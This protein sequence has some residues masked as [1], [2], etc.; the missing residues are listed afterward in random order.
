MNAITPTPPSFLVGYWRPWNEAADAFASY[1]DYTRDVSLAKYSAGI[2]GTY[3]AQASQERVQAIERAS[4]GLGQGFAQ[5]F[6]QL[7]GQLSSVQTGLEFLN[8][9]MDMLVEQQRLSNV[10]LQNI[11]ELLRV[12]NSEKERQHS[13]ELGI[14]FF[15]N[16]SK[17]PDLYDD[18]LEMLLKA[19]SLMKQD[20]FVL[21]RIGCIYLYVTKHLDPAKAIDYFSRAGKYASV[22]SDPK[23]L[24][25]A[26]VLTASRNA[27]GSTLKQSPDGIR[28]LAADAYEKAAF[29]AYILDK[30]EQAVGLQQKALAMNPSPQ[31]SFTLAKYQVRHGAVNDAVVSL[32]DALNRGPLLLGAVFREI[33][34]LNEPSVLAL[35]DTHGIA[36]DV[37]AIRG[38]RSRVIDCIIQNTKTQWGNALNRFPG[39]R[40]MLN[41]PQRRG[42]RQPHIKKL[43]NAIGK[44]AQ[45]INGYTK[46]VDE[47]VQ[48]VVHVLD[49][50]I[51]TAGEH[52]AP[53]KDLFE[54][55][56]REVESCDAFFRIVH[57]CDGFDEK[58]EGVLKEIH[59]RLNESSRG[60]TPLDGDEQ[61]EVAKDFKLPD[62]PVFGEAIAPLIVHEV[63]V[64]EGQIIEP[65]NCLFEVEYRTASQSFYVWVE[66]PHGG[67][68]A[69]V[70][71][72][73]GDTVVVG[74]TVVLLD[75]GGTR[76]FAQA[77]SVPQESGRL[78]PTD[79][80][81]AV[82][83]VDALAIVAVADGQIS[84]DELSAIETTIARRGFAVSGDLVREWAKNAVAQ[85]RA[86]GVPAFAKE[87]RDRM[88]AHRAMSFLADV[89]KAMTEVAQRDGVVQENERRVIEWFQ[90]HCKN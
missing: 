52:C 21:H 35:V 69:K 25:L 23:A 60:D 14:K 61:A 72:K 36:K 32:R 75:S 46:K 76:P 84:S 65:G 87:V 82:L 85:M 33:D 11:A 70:L 50:A 90:K 38:L 28:V 79:T 40:V 78:Q 27:A 44:M 59:K 49:T 19:E 80:K 51:A 77:Q 15:V 6:G 54:R 83:F 24:R 29:A 3:I 74:Q 48:K 8:R 16:A 43:A 71:V 7:S 17:D 26:S 42:S 55:S 37:F 31:N 18:A 58:Q 81:Q 41:E 89:V 10:L 62:Y 53:L 47:K 22:E 4:A 34:L 88:A 1:L 9:N 73:E 39:Y 30:H 20:Y 2:V 12:P 64:A 66:C 67:R 13:I 45:L 86:K 56:K 5:G 68:I 57:S 63:F